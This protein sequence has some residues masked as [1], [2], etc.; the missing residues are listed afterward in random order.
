MPVA[1]PL[2]LVGLSES[3]RYLGT[4]TAEDEEMGSHLQ[5]AKLIR[6]GD[7]WLETKRKVLTHGSP[8]VAPVPGKRRG[9]FLNSCEWEL[10]PR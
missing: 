10:Y 3:T 6:F 4:S 5:D 8:G 7:F 9:R 2:S 1:A